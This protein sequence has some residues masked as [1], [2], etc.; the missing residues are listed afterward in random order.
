MFLWEYIYKFNFH[1]F[2]SFTVVF[3]PGKF[4]TVFLSLRVILY[5]S[6][7]QFEIRTEICMIIQYFIGQLCLLI[8]SKLN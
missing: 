8:P 3:L 1:V 5:E 4:W 7:R 2:S 6:S